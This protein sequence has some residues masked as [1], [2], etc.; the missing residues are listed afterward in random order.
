M[1]KNQGSNTAWLFCKLTC[2][3]PI[4]SIAENA[5]YSQKLF[6]SNI[7]RSAQKVNRYIMHQNVMNFWLNRQYIPGGLILIFKGPWNVLFLPYFD[8]IFG[9]RGWGVPTQ[10][11][12]PPTLD[13]LMYTNHREVCQTKMQVRLF[14]TVDISVL[15]LRMFS[16]QASWRIYWFINKLILKWWIVNFKTWWIVNFFA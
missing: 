5:T 11:T 4:H 15:K 10:G 13:P 9:E 8:N 3:L 7:Y 1:Q 2:I 14:S 16:N 6:S 12:P